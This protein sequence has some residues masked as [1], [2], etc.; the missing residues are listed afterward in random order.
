MNMTSALARLLTEAPLRDNFRVDAQRTARE[1]SV[2]A[3]SID[4][5]C[6]LDP[7]RLDA[8]AATLLSKRYHEAF[9][10]L[11]ET[12]AQ[13]QHNG[14]DVFME[15]AHSHWPE[16]HR[17]HLIDAVK[18]CQ[19]LITLG[20]RSVCRS[21]YNRLRFALKGGRLAVHLVADLPVGE[22]KRRALQLLY[23]P[24]NGIPRQYAFYLGI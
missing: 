13:L 20:S 5:F 3:D 17:R 8:Q 22:K 18:F 4:T 16:G 12:C 14:R 6:A 2:D 11:P 23:R 1:L 7:S 21:E 9:S 10:L 24:A 19:F 15:Y